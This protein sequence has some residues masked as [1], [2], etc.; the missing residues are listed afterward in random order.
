[1]TGSYTSNS[2]KV[3]DDG[4][5]INGVIGTSGTI[6]FDPP[7]TASSAVGPVVAHDPG[8]V[9]G[10][11]IAHDPGP[12]ATDTIVASTP[13]ETLTGLGAKDTFVFNFAN[14]G[15]ATV[16]DFHP[17]AD[18]LQ[19]GNAIFA[20]AQGALAA[21]HDDGQGNTVVGLDAH[22]TITLAGVVKAQLHA[23]DFHVV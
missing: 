8:P 18:T 5:L 23:T 20:N 19:F 11:V 9:V 2:F 21:T 3:A 4:N 14:V 6:I 12:K 16:T 15:K 10:P 1:L 17:A 22:D 13:N 7:G